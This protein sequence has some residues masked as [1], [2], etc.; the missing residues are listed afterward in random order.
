MSVTLTLQLGHRGARRISSISDGLF[1]SKRSQVNV[2]SFEDETTAAA[3]AV[4]QWINSAGHNRNVG[5]QQLH[6]P[7]VCFSLETIS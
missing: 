1:G 5:T 3:A 6:H 2:A 4:N 7:T